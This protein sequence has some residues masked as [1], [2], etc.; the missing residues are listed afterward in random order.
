MGEENAESN[1][2]VFELSSQA[3]SLVGM[4]C[5]AR[6]HVQAKEGGVSAAVGG[7]SMVL[8]GAK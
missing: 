7:Y 3:L 5:L 8:E 6:T 4:R 2:S 1:F